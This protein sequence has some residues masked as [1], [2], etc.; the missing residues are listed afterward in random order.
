[1]TPGRILKE[2][3]AQHAQLRALIAEARASADRC[4]R[5]ED[6]REKLLGAMAELMDAVRVH[7]RREEMLIQEVLPSLDGW[8]D[9]RAQFMTN[10]HIREH[11]EV[12]HSLERVRTADDPKV[13]ARRVIS[14]LRKLLVHMSREEVAFIRPEVLRD[15]PRKR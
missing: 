2:L 9:G 8:G 6:G 15:G 14:V 4:L 10:E 3:L 7:N 1:M 13:G 12:F 11:G 5:G